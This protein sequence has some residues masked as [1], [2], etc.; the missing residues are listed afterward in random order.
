MFREGRPADQVFK[1]KEL[2]FRRYLK[3]HFADGQIPDAYFN[4]PPSLNRQKYSEPRDVIFSEDGCFDGWGVLEYRVDQ[5]SFDLVHESAGYS[6]FPKHTP[7]EANY[8]H[9][10]IHCRRESDQRP[11]VHPNKAVR[12]KY[13]A[14]LSQQSPKIR[15]EA[16]K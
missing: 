12:K 1:P 8:S 4:F 6:F 3:E 2:L 10:E 5:M 15:I 7:D 9:T 11:E 16:Q 13:R 14:K